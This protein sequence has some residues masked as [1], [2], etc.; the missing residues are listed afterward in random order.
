LSFSQILSQGMS[1]VMIL[2]KMFSERKVM[3][4][5]VISL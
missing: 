4:E 3:E 1:P 2:A 5:E